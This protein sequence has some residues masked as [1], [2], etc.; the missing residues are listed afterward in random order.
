MEG[1]GRQLCGHIIIFSLRVPKA[2][3]YWTLPSFLSSFHQPYLEHLPGVICYARYL[4]SLFHS[5]IHSLNIFY[6]PS[7]QL[8]KFKSWTR[9]T[10]SLPHL[11]SKTTLMNY[12]PKPW[13]FGKEEYKAG[14]PTHLEEALLTLGWARR[15]RCHLPRSAFSKDPCGNFEPGGPA[16]F[17]KWPSIAPKPQLCLHFI[18]LLPK[19]YY[20]WVSLS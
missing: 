20:D 9:K 1:N 16:S 3:E 12:L 11:E 4:T 5:F 18:S 2:T 13:V 17:H 14:A 7:A 19:R 15:M 10:G 6:V 8:Q